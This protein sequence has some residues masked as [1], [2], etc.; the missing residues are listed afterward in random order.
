MPHEAC[1]PCTQLVISSRVSTSTCSTTRTH[2]RMH[3]LPHSPL[4]SW[5]Q[6]L[7]HKSMHTTP[8]NNS[9]LVGAIHSWPL[10]LTS[11]PTPPNTERRRPGHTRQQDACRR[12]RPTGCMHKVLPTH[13]QSCHPSRHLACNLLHSFSPD[14]LS[15]S[16]C[17]STAGVQYYTCAAVLC[18][19]DMHICSST[20]E[21][22][23]RRRSV[24]HIF[25]QASTSD[26]QAA[27]D[28]RACEYHMMAG[29]H[30]AEPAGCQTH[31]HKPACINPPLHPSMMHTHQHFPCVLQHRQ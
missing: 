13:K 5:P 26:Q 27:S 4:L 21:A 12:Y 19:R 8:N 16:Y 14:F 7:L 30:V 1:A 24:C 28:A 11:N 17:P 9:T 25:M 2:K 6:P 29:L 18:Q 22:V 10:L 23:S 15:F 20:G 3:V 31:P